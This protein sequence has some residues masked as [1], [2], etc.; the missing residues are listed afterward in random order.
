MPG[1]LLSVPFGEPATL[2]LADLARQL[3]A[4]DVLAP[5]TVTVPS[6]AAG[7]TLRRRLAE[8]GGSRPCAPDHFACARPRH[9]WVGAHPTAQPAGTATTNSSSW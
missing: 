9:T 2:A 7:T 5:L 6:A 1:R 8:A 3:R 4:G